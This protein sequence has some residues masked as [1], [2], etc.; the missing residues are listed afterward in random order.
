[1]KKFIVYLLVIVLA[2]SLGFAVFYFVK[3]DEVISIS[4]S[5]MYVDKDETF[6]IDLN[7]NNKKVYTDISVSSSNEEIVSYNEET[8]EFTAHNGGI[9]RINFKTTNSK[10][11]NLSC[12]VIVGDGSITS[13][14][15]IDSVEK[16]AAIGMGGQ[17][18]DENEVAITGVT[19]GAEGYEEYLSNACYKLMN[20]IDVSLIN[21]GYWVPLKS[22]NGQ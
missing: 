5:S 2:V 15:Y 11:R 9:A 12:D 22:F 7:H 14:F 19:M 10:F 4:A 18:Y 16:L 17:A 20:N 13:P 1:M 6:T 21:G 8:N 3:D